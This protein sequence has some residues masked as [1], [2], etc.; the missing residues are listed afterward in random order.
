M[1]W[2]MSEAEASE[3][4]KAEAAIL[5]LMTEESRIK[6]YIISIAKCSPDQ[7]E[8]AVQYAKAVLKKDRKMQTLMQDTMR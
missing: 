1:K 5:Q 8:Q 7:K 4:L 6:R 2:S 3:I